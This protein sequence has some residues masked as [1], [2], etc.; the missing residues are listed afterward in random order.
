M[1]KYSLNIYGANDEIIKTFETDVV[2]WGVFMN[3]VKLQDEIKEKSMSEQIG[4]ISDF[5][6]S[7]FPTMT[8]EDLAGADV[9][10]IFSTFAQI[11]NNAGKI[12]TG[13]TSK[14][15]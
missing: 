11:T 9:G 12:K 4:A 8:I 10:D 3:A 14:N 7:V 6:I 15:A 1:K 2:R 5:M 13:N